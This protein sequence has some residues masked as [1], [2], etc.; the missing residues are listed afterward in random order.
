MGGIFKREMSSDVSPALIKHIIKI[1]K[2]KHSIVRVWMRARARVRL[3][4]KGKEKENSK[5][6]LR[7]DFFEDGRER[8]DVEN[9]I[10]GLGSGIHKREDILGLCHEDGK[11]LQSSGVE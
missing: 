9:E 5:E 8:R 2:L 1:I 10:Q 4:K 11:L 6:S 7:R 3:G